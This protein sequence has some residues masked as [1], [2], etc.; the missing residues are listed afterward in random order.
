MLF[1]RYRNQKND[2]I[3]YVIAIF[4][5]GGSTCYASSCSNDANEI[6]KLYDLQPSIPEGGYYKLTYKLDD[7]TSDIPKSTAI[8]YL[9]K[10]TDVSLMHKLSNDIIYHYYSGDPVNM[11]LLN[12]DGTGKQIILG[13]DVLNQQ[14][15]QVVVAKNTWIGSYVAQDGCYALMGTTMSPGFDPNGYELGNQSELIK[16]YPAYA[17]EIIKLTSASL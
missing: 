2:I 12:P 10:S 8:F 5:V 16:A 15:V 6:I 3:A 7:T 11:L 4:I 13:N 17:N 14:Q 1:S 9:L